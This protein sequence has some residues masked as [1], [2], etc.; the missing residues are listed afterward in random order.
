LTLHAAHRGYRDFLQ[1]IW[2]E[3]PLYPLIL[4][5][6]PLNRE[7]FIILQLPRKK[8]LF[9]WRIFKLSQNLQKLT[10]FRRDTNDR[11]ST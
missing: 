11:S 2:K 6:N 1:K 10:T 5:K 7:R 8:F 9:L 4:W 3:T